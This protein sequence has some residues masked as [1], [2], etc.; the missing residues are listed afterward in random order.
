MMAVDA[1]VSVRRPGCSLSLSFSLFLSLSSLSLS[2]TGAG[3]RGAQEKELDGGLGL[4]VRVAG[5]QK[6]EANMAI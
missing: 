6:Q 2:Q 4:T 5:G 3:W 1:G